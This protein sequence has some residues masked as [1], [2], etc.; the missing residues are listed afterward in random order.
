MRLCVI[1]NSHAG[2][3]KRAWDQNERWKR[4]FDLEFFAAR[5]RGLE[6][7][8]RKEQ[9]II[10]VWEKTERSFEFTSGGRTRIDLDRYEAFVIFGAHSHP[11]FQAPDAFFSDAAV[12]RALLDLCEG[13]AFFHM[14]KLLNGVSPR[15]VIIGHT[16]L[17]AANL[18]VRL[19]QKT[20]NYHFGISLINERL[21]RA[22]GGV[23]VAQPEATIVN[24]ENTELSY[25]KGSRRLAVGV[26]NDHAFHPSQDITH[27]NERFGELWL[28][29]LFDRL[30]P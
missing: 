16:P 27:M 23:M 8:T 11:Y 2:S 14:L 1:G 18:D 6:G 26:A 7:C 25:S 13:K 12:E 17:A 22:M 9:E 5:G 29:Q 19:S 10:P 4:D 15:P 28:M 24:G 21:L 30:V 3:L 20:E